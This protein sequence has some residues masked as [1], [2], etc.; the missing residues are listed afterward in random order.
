MTGHTDAKPYRNRQDYTN[1]ELSTDRANAAR[2]YLLKFGVKPERIVY[3]T[4]KSATDPLIKD[5]PFSPQNRRISMIL[6]RIGARA[7]PSANA[8]INR[9]SGPS[10]K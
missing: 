10:K 3:V 9:I 2:R 4:G 5:D 7:Y 6:Q 8:S 1:W